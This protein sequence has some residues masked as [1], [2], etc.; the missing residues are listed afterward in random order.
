MKRIILLLTAMLLSWGSYA[1]LAEEGFEGAWLPP[2]WTIADNGIGIVNSWTQITGNDATPAYEGT[3]AAFINK[4]NVSGTVPPEDWLITPLFTVP[5]TPELRFFSR[6]TFPTDNG[7]LY[8]VMITNGDP[9]DMAGYSLLEDWTEFEINPSQTDYTEKVVAIPAAYIGT[10]V[11]IAFVMTG[12]NGDRWLIDNVKVVSECLAPEN[13]SA[14][15]RTFTSATLS[16]DNPSGA[17][18]WEIEITGDT[19]APTGSGTEYSGTLPYPA[20]GL[21]I[22]TDYKFYVRALCSDGGESTWAGP[23]YFGTVAPGD[24][25]TTPHI[26]TALPY[27]DTDDTGHYFDFYNG[28]PGGCGTANYMQY[29]NGNDVIYAYTPTVTGEVSVNITDLTDDYA[30]ACVY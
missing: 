26:V 29:L 27:T 2:G 1:Q 3:H 7:T 13:L 20:T 16:W 5:A 24:S 23:F 30:G 11:H 25:C 12:D 21:T 28:K 19:E 15:D 18:S 14:S 10:D 17:N 4:E 9:A 8:R 22:D 6:L